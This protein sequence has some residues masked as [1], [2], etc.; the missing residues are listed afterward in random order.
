MSEVQGALLSPHPA[1]GLMGSSVSRE[2]FAWQKNVTRVKIAVAFINTNPSKHRPQA[3]ALKHK[4]IS[5]DLKAQM[6]LLFLSVRN[7]LWEI[8]CQSLGSLYMTQHWMWEHT[9][10]TQA[11]KL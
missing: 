11:P 1:S 9:R 3:V 8:L 10:Q 6:H 5:Q 4:Y 2:T 7:S